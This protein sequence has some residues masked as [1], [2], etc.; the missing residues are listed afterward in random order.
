VVIE[1]ATV[2]EALQRLT[3]EVGPDA[4][5]LRADRVRRGGIAGFFARE[6]VEIE[7]EAPA[8]ALPAP[9]GGVDAVFGRMLAEAEESLETL[10]RPRTA[11]ATAQPLRPEAPA[12]PGPQVSTAPVIR[13]SVVTVGWDT[14]RM[15]E[16][17]LPGAL[18]Q[19]VAALDPTDDLGHLTALAAVLAP[20]CGPFPEG[21]H[22]LVGP[23]AER[24]RSAVALP[25]SP[26]GLLHLVVGDEL[27][28]SLPGVP[29]LVSWVSDRGAARAISLALGTG[30]KLGYGIG[31]GF[32]APLRRISAL[33][34]ALAVRD[35]MERT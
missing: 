31:S 21:G 29:S 10:D 20:V 2:E 24:L 18:V 15:L 28:E 9:S 6:A 3:L 1:A 33:E 4:R 16:L 25:E 13:N 32:G 8:P 22:H 26:E 14:A 30:A 19:A 12:P 23:R 17:G 11:V 5:I 27:P 34:A 35:L 7:A